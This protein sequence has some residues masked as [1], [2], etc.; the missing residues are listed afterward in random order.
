MTVIKVVKDRFLP[1]SC[2]H[3]NMYKVWSCGVWWV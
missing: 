2:C 1:L 3:K